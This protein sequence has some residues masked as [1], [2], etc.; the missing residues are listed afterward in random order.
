MGEGE[1]GVEGNCANESWL[2]YLLMDIKC[3]CYV[4]YVCV[5]A[6]VDMLCSVKGVGK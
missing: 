1:E 5:C 4:L 6:R 2:L 3:C